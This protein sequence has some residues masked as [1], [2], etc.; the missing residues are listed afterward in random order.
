MGLRGEAELLKHEEKN[1]LRHSAF[2]QSEVKDL[3]SWR[4]GT[5]EEDFRR[6]LVKAQN[7]EGGELD[8]LL[9]K[10]D[11]ALWGMK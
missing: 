9:K 6:D 3:F 7:F 5:E 10:E 1:E 4:R 8:K 2:S 11:L